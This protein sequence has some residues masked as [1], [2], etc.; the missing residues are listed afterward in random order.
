MTPRVCVHD[1]AS[2]APT[3]LSPA[4][5]PTRRTASVSS[6]SEVD[7]SSSWS[8]AL[9]QVSVAGNQTRGL[10]S[11]ERPVLLEVEHHGPG[12]AEG[13]HERD[14]AVVAR[15]RA[16]HRAVVATD[17]QGLHAENDAERH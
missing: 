10:Q 17:P 2:Q 8:H 12:L 7:G 1:L 3:A 13:V 9:P 14:D 5:S 4:S 6:T 15:G 11:P 16:G